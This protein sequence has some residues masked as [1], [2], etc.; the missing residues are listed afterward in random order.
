LAAAPG[1][2]LHVFAAFREGNGGIH[3]AAEYFLWN[4]RSVRQ[5]TEA[6]NILE[7]GLPNINFSSVNAECFIRQS[8]LPSLALICNQAALIDALMHALF[9]SETS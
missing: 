2:A 8:A 3:A 9:E 5:T 1:Q 6:I 4:F 7:R